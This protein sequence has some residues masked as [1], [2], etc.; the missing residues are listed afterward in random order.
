VRRDAIL[1]QRKQLPIRTMVARRQ[2]YRQ[3]QATAGHAG[4]GTTEV[5]P[6]RDAICVT[7]R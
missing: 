3:M 2:D 4:A 5:A 6:G 1:A 7:Q